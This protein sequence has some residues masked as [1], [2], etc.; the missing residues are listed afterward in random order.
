MQ[1]IDGSIQGWDEYDQS[2]ETVL[3]WVDML[4]DSDYDCSLLFDHNRAPNR[5]ETFRIFHK[6][7]RSRGRRRGSYSID[8]S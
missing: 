2:M 4:N 3:D 1:I 7:Y 8:R 6:Y 5:K